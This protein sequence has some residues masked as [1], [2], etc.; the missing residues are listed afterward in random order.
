MSSVLTALPFE[1]TLGDG[2][3]GRVV[4]ALDVLKKFCETFIVILH[5]GRP[6]NVVRIRVVSCASTSEKKIRGR[7]KG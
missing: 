3:D 6:M 7:N 1:D 4:P 2:G 5:L